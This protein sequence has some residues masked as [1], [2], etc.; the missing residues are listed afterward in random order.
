VGAFAGILLGCHG[1]LIGLALVAVSSGVENPLHELLWPGLLMS[2]ALALVPI[3]TLELLYRT[4]GR[5]LTFF[6]MLWGMLLF[7]GG[8]M[9]LLVNSWIAPAIDRYPDFVR[10]L[11]SVGT[12]YRVADWISPTLFGCSVALMTIAAI[13]IFSG[14]DHSSESGS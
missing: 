14:E 3:V 7:F 11:E 12:V 8:L 13:R 6:I 4:V 10:H 2:L 1:W 9:T 5:S